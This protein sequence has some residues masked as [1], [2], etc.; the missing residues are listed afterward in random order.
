MPK[1]KDIQYSASAMKNAGHVKKKTAANAPQW[2]AI[3]KLAAGRVPDSHVL[4]VIRE[5]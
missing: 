5:S 4:E 1:L 2:N 3:Q